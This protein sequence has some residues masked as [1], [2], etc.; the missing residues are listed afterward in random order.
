MKP[1]FWIPCI[2]LT[3]LLIAVFCLNETAS[4]D[5]KEKQ[6]ETK[7]IALES[8]YSTN[9][10]KGLKAV[11]QKEMGELYRQS[12]KMGAS[13][14][15]L[16]RGDDIV[17]AIQASWEVFTGGQPVSEPASSVGNS[18]SEQYW[19][20]AYLG[21]SGP[22][23]AWLVKSVEV[24]GENIRLT[25]T[26]PGSK[27]NELHPYFVWVPLGKLKPTLYSLELFE[28]DQQQATILRR[29]AVPEK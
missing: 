3:G 4:G 29:V 17:A 25:F 1:F 14:V 19:F 11:E 22:G 27:L 8:I 16:A 5:D 21:V 2:L 23:G 24:K 26:N 15:F 6:V 9:G 7:K 28:A 12:I 18:K 20:V 10:Q 13:N